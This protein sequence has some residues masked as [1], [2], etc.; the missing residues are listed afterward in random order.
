MELMRLWP[1]PK[2]PETR[3]W[4]LKVIDRMASILATILIGWVFATSCRGAEEKPATLYNATGRPTVYSQQS[5]SNFLAAKLTA[6]EIALVKNPLASN[7]KMDA[8]ARKI[9]AGTTNELLKAKMIFDELVRRDNRGANATR[10]AQEAYVVW[11]TPEVGFSCEEY[12][13]LYVAL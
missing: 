6:Q 10:T 5:L 13:E 3:S 7:P 11:K 1:K 8:W 4:I 12:A 9:T 2:I